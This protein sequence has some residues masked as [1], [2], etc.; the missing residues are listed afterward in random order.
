MEF[1]TCATS[2][3][4]NEDRWLY[5][6]TR[7]E[8][9]KTLMET[10][11]KRWNAKGYKMPNLVF[12]NVD[13]RQ[14]NIPMI[15]DGPISYVS[16]FSPSIFETLMSGKTGYELMIEKLDSDRYACIH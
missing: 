5:S 8:N 2:G 4:R 13:A 1:D 15:G 16:G 14:N 7:I 10:I 6:N 11:E 9:K 3:P 12:W